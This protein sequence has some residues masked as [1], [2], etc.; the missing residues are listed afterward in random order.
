MHSLHIFLR[1]HARMTTSTAAD[2]I[3]DSKDV[4]VVFSNDRDAKSAEINLI[5]SDGNEK[6][7]DMVKL[8]V[9]FLIRNDWR[10]YIH[11][12]CHDNST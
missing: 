6:S 8:E 1:F 4:F 11:Q 9:E 12:R 10:G 5:D 2:T 7:I 3:P